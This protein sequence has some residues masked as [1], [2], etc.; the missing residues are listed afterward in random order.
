MGV[1]LTARTVALCAQKDA[2]PQ[3]TPLLVW[4]SA[5]SDPGIGIKPED[6]DTLFRRH[7]SDLPVVHELRG[8]YGQQRLKAT[9]DC[10]EQG[11]R[12][13]PSPSI[14]IPTRAEGH[15]H[16]VLSRNPPTEFRRSQL[17]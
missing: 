5:S 7:G 13:L 4:P 10:S 1:I 17:P 11:P 16:Y 2:D 6:R 14:S 9:R 15:K 12:S 8:L 3:Q